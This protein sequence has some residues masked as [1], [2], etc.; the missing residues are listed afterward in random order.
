MLEHLSIHSQPSVGV[1]YELVEVIDGTDNF[2]I[3]IF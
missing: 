3:E 2:E 1:S